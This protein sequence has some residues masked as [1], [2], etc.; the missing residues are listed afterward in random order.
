MS[1]AHQFLLLHNCI[2]YFTSIYCKFAI[3]SGAE[4][5]YVS[6]ALQ[7][8]KIVVNEDGTKAAA[9]TSEY[10]YIQPLLGFKGRAKHKAVCLAGETVLCNG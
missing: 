7:K 4:P 9:A 6:K 5:V 1:S 3:F 8:A 10:L 2:A